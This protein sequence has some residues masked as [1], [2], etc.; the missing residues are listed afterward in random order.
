MTFSCCGFRFPTT[1]PQRA[2]CTSL[3]VLFCFF[4]VFVFLQSKYLFCFCNTSAFGMQQYWTKSYR[5]NFHQPSKPCQGLWNVCHS[6]LKVPSPDHLLQTEFKTEYSPPYTHEIW[7]YRAETDLI[8]RSIESF[9][10]SK[11]FFR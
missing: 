10:W 9:D 6:K 5:S 1:T 11:L 8:N 2:N 3:F 4:F 7:E